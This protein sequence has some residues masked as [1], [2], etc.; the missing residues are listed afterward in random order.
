[1]PLLLWLQCLGAVSGLNWHFGVRE[2]F[3]PNP[4]VWHHSGGCFCL[5]GFQKAH[6]RAERAEA[7]GCSAEPGL[8]SHTPAARKGTRS[9]PGTAFVH[10]LYFVFAA[11]L[12][13]NSRY[14]ACQRLT[15]CD[16]P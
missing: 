9:A 12:R 3:F 7:Q 14:P 10:H 6:A 5:M 8:Q 11:S 16:I 1:M 4:A 15:C 13:V 2:A